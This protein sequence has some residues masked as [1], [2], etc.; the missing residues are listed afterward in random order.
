MLS[1]VSSFWPLFWGIIGGG[2]ALAV[3]VPVLLAGTPL[4]RRP[5]RTASVIELRPHRDEPD[6][7]L[8]ATAHK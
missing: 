8:A 1:N 3:L 2:A 6:A 5:G 7:R 4:P